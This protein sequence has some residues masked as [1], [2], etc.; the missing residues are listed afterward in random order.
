MQRG[1]HKYKALWG[2]QESVGVGSGGG[3]VQSKEEEEG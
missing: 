3:G 2:L 1:A